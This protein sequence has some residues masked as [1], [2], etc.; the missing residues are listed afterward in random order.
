MIWSLPCVD[1][2]LNFENNFKKVPYLEEFRNLVLEKHGLNTEHKLNCNALN[3][4]VLYK[5]GVVSSKASNNTL[6]EMTLYETLEKMFSQHQIDFVNVFQ[7]SLMEQLGLV[8]AADILIGMHRSEL[9]LFL[10]VPKHSA[11]LEIFSY[12][13]PPTVNQQYKAIAEWR[14]LQYRWWGGTDNKNYYDQTSASSIA[15]QIEKV[16]AKIYEKLCFPTNIR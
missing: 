15:S 16:A 6:Q 5:P 4:V 13:T 11:V 7:T 14:S 1:S 3:I 10:F 2:P 8:A 12:D 9:A